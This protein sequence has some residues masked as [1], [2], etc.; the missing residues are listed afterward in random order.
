M[1]GNGGPGLDPARH[2][3]HYDR[4]S[5]AVQ[6]KLARTPPSSRV[7]SRASVSRSMPS[8]RNRTDP[9]P[10]SAFTPAVWLDTSGTFAPSLCHR[11][12]HTP[13]LGVSHVQP[14]FWLIL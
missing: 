12:L 4:L 9:S 7:A 1:I 8:L 11:L 6:S 14:S 2:E 5:L 10:R 13:T 3:M